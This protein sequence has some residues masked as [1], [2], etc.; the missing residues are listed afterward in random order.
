[1]RILLCD[2]DPGVLQQMEH[3]LSK[4]F[5]QIGAKPPEIALYIDGEELIRSRDT[6]R[7][8]FLTWR[9]QA[10]VGSIPGSD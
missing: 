3:L 5:Q 2:D 6:G 10:S 8:H 7:L 1:M 4:F 9:C